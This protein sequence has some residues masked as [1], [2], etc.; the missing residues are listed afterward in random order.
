M[1]NNIVK[2]LRIFNLVSVI[3]TTIL[4][5]YMPSFLRSEPSYTT[6]SIESC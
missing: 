5:P 1:N 2:N 6:T 3:S 4:Y